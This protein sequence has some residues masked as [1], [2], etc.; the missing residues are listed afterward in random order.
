MLIGNFF[1][2]ATQSLQVLFLRQ[3]PTNVHNPPTSMTVL[4]ILRDDRVM[5]LVLADAVGMAFLENCHIICS[6]SP[7]RWFPLQVSK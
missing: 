1:I 5:E 4:V 2:P 7:F 6:P 3:R